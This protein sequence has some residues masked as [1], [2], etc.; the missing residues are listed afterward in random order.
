VTNVEQRLLGHMNSVPCLVI[1]SGSDEFV[2]EHV[3]KEQLCKSFVEAMGSKSRY[4]IVEGGHHY[5][6]G[7]EKEL[8]TVVLEFLSEI[9]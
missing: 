7:K 4:Y 6:E 2:P 1:F 8:H 3:N 9:D 5:L